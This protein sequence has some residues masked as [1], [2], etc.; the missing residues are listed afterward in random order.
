[1]YNE[2]TL[3]GTALNDPTTWT[4]KN[5]QQVSRFYLAT[6]EQ[7]LQNGDW[8]TKTQRHNVAG[9]NKRS[10]GIQNKVKKG[11]LLL[12]RGKLIYADR[13]KDGVQYQG[14]EIEISYLRTLPDTYATKTTPAQEKPRR[15]RQNAPERNQRTAG[16][17]GDQILQGI[18]TDGL[19]DKEEPITRKTARV[20]LETGEVLDGPND[21]P[22]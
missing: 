10:T 9:W 6:E 22:F 13:E 17:Y 21:L 2:I 12:I 16:Q 1:M 14:A 18:D 5:G 7:Y 11:A 15:T 20:D 8:Q 4:L 3:I 19:F